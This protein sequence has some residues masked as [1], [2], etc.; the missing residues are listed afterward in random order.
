MASGLLGF[1]SHGGLGIPYR[2]INLVKRIFSK[3]HIHH[4]LRLRRGLFMVCSVGRLARKGH[5]L[6]ATLSRNKEETWRTKD[7]RV[8]P[9]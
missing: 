5:R 1:V 6:E 2:G 4:M 7:F 3:N 9:F 8:V